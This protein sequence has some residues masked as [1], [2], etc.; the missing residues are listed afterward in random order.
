MTD[1]VTVA[2]FAE[3]PTAPAA[4]VA[5][6]RIAPSVEVPMRSIFVRLLTS[7]ALEPFKYLAMAACP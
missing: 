1:A 6:A 7:R 5:P 2:S 4:L 3:V